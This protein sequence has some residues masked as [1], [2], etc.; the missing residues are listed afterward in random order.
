MGKGSGFGK[1]IL[2]GDMFVG[3]GVPAIVSAIPQHTTALVERASGNGWFLKDSRPEVPGYKTSKNAQQ[4]ESIGIILRSMGIDTDKQR[5]SIELNGNLIAG[6]GIGASAA[7]CVALVRA[8]DD[9]MAL[10]LTKEQVNHIAWEGE[11]AYHGKPSGID[12]TVSCFGGIMVF[13]K[14]VDGGNISVTKINLK[15][16]IEVV[17]VNSG[18]TVNTANK[19]EYIAGFAKKHPS[20]YDTYLRTTTEQSMDMTEALQQ[21]DLEQVGSLMDENH[22]ILIDM[23][24]S[25]DVIVHL[26]QLAKEQGALGAKVT[27]GGRGGY[28]VALTPGEELQQRVASAF[29]AEG[30]RTF[31]T[32]IGLV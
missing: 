10:G 25:H 27:G 8:L 15:Q 6:S 26:A 20:K 1:T 21:F 4:E 2:I 14:A 19:R 23:G 5:L 28:M 11:T 24:L 7:S 13:Q 9:E 12:N 22:T 16:P 30:F 31:S 18:V 32:Q 3:L 17:L 29:E